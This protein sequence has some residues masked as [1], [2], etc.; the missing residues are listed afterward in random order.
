MHDT[1]SFAHATVLI[2]PYLEIFK[3]EDIQYPDEPSGIASWVCAGVDLV[4]YPGES[5]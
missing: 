4:H 2:Y 5:S 1:H 3:A